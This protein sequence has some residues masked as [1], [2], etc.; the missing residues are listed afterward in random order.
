MTRDAS[1]SGLP[2]L[3]ELRR[4][5]CAPDLDAGLLDSLRCDPRASVAT[6]V[7]AA[8]RRFER[9]AK[10]R[11]KR[12]TM[13]ELE[14]DLLARGL[15]VIAGVD[16]AGLGPLAGPVVAAAVI[17]GDA[18]GLEGIDDSKK[19]DEKRRELLAP[20]I[21]ERAA[22]WAIGIAEVSEIDELNVYHA[23]LL[24]MRRAVEGLNV[25]PDHVLVDARCIPGL[26]VEQSAHIKGDARSLSIAAASIVAKTYRDALMIE[27]DRTH[28]GY[29]LARHKGYGTPEHQDALRRLGASPIHRISY[30]AVRALVAR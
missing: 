29:G 27:L 4:L 2:P 19:L 5:L 9:S 20:Q 24:A 23:G 11:Q 21:R 14:R 10:Q 28:P 1:R 25:K 30:E 26:D 15:T 12:E 6:L 18:A 17:L 7:A 16:E 13:L 3:A 8:G 22:A